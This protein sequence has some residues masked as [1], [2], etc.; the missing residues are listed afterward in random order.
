MGNSLICGVRRA[1]LSLDQRRHAVPPPPPPPPP[2]PNIAHFN[3]D[4]GILQVESTTPHGLIGDGSEWVIISNSTIYDGT[5]NVAFITSDVLFDVAVGG[6]IGDATGN[7]AI[8]DPPPARPSGASTGAAGIVDLNFVA[9]AE[10]L[11]AGGDPTGW[12]VKVNGVSVPIDSVSCGTGSTAPSLF[13]TGD[14]MATGDVITVSYDGTGDF[15]DIHYAA[16]V[17]PFTDFIVT[18]TL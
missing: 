9:A 3:D 16:G 7:W 8:T 6:W 18:N 15:T 2:V 10:G 5:Y 12:T 13:L 4:G 17:P 14:L 1:S 11:S